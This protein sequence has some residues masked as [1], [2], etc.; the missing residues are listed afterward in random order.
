MIT[1]A[2]QQELPLEL[3]LLEP[4]LL[5]R[6]MLGHLPRRTRPHLR[7]MSGGPPQ[8]TAPDLWLLQCRMAHTAMA[9][10]P[11]PMP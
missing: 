2:R 1:G 3:L 5:G 7:H 11:T 9:Q 6:P 10:D 8:P 4:L